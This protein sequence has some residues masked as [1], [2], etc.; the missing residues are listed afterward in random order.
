MVGAIGALGIEKIQ[1]AGGAALVSVLGDVA[2][3]PGLIDV[4]AAVQLDDFI[5]GTQS[6]VSV[7]DVGAD[8]LGGFEGLLL[9]LGDGVAG[10]GDLA[11][12][13]VEDRQVDVEEKG[14]TVDSRGVRVAEAGA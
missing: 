4:A 13:A 12:V 10:A 2:G 6:G 14:A 1:E 11:L 9:R 7:G 8:L 3:L 5:V